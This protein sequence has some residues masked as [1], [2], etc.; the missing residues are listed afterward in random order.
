MQYYKT[1]ASGNIAAAES[2]GE[3]TNVTVVAVA[4]TLTL[5]D[6]GKVYSLQGATDGA[7]ITLPAVATSAGVKYRFVVGAAFATTNW[8]IVADDDIIEGSC[9]VAGVVIPASNENTISF[10][11]TVEELGDWVEIV[12]DGTSWFASGQSTT[13]ASVTFTAP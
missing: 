2:A 3:E 5:A 7:A 6:S 1:D 9:T 10:V 13:A 11:A 12:C 8:T 4:T